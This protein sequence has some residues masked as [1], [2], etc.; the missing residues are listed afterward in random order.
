MITMELDERQQQAL[1]A[2]IDM[3]LRGAGLNAHEPAGIIIQ[4]LGNAKS[5]ADSSKVVPMAAAE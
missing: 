1:G 3:A 4:A 5:A 2:L